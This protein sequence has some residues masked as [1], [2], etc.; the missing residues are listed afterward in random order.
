MH[1]YKKTIKTITDYDFRIQPGIRIL[2]NY[3]QEK[4]A[5]L[6]WSDNNYNLR[7]FIE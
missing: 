7:E 6:P 3:L 4:F 2:S 1:D 5:R